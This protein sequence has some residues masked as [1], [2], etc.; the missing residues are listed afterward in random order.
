MIR[1]VL[2]S[3]G[4]KEKVTYLLPPGNEADPFEMTAII[5]FNDVL[6]LRSLLQPAGAFSYPFYLARVQDE[7]C[8][9][10]LF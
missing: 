9:V 10:V 7:W 2:V 4:L 6:S 3:V 5:R 1:S 8:G